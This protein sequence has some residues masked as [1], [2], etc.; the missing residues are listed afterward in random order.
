MFLASSVGLFL[1]DIT[2][3]PSSLA[4]VGLFCTRC[5]REALSTDR[6]RIRPGILPF[7]LQESDELCK[8][9]LKVM[10]YSLSFQVFIT[11]L[12]LLHTG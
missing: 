11:L 2:N 7:S 5:G 12:E 9:S 8:I 4:S 3:C 1:F 6:L 10:A